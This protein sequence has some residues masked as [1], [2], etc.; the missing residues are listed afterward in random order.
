M[1]CDICNAITSPVVNLLQCIQVSLFGRYLAELSAGLLA[2]I[3]LLFHTF[4]QPLHPKNAMGVHT[5]S[6]GTYN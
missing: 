4:S 3:T 5:L 1:I 2:I 6:N